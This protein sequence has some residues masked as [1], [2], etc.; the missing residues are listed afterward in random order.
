M[1][2][3]MS[4]QCHPFAFEQTNQTA[5]HGKNTLRPSSNCVVYLQYVQFQMP[6]SHGSSASHRGCKL[7]L[8]SWSAG[9]A[10][11]GRLS[12]SWEQLI[13][14]FDCA[15]Q[16]E[17]LHVDTMHGAP[18]TTLSVMF[19]FPELQARKV[20]SSSPQTHRLCHLAAHHCNHSQLQKQ[21]SEAGEALVLLLM[22]MCLQ[23]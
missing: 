17:N 3:S 12:L 6:A 22:K 10:E 1:Q 20:A 5:S 16:R 23:S 7:Q 8:S 21:H 18:L 9:S 11:P 15:V 14:R 4:W 19:A 2:D 13:A